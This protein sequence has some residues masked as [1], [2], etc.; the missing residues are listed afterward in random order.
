M[1]LAKDF[2]PQAVEDESL[3]PAKET[4][5][6]VERRF[7]RNVNLRP[8]L[9][10]A[11]VPGSLFDEDLKVQHIP[12][13]SRAQE[14]AMHAMQPV[15]LV[16]AMRFSSLAGASR[17]D[18]GC[19]FTVERACLSGWLTLHSPSLAGVEPEAAGQHAE[20]DAGQEQSADPWSQHAL[21]V[22]RHVAEHLCL[23]RTVLVR[24]W[25]QSVLTK[26]RTCRWRRLICPHVWPMSTWR[27]SP[28]LCTQ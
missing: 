17:Y 15:L 24:M 11:D 13:M 20:Q 6:E 14:L 9:Y 21:P 5:E 2:R 12:G 23:V 28:S 10:G 18:C 4:P 26:E 3:P 16:A 19:Q 8:P 1:S 7:W 27:A 25:G 22:L